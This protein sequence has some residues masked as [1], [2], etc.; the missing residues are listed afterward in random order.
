MFT[1]EQAR[2][3][4]GYY[5]SLKGDASEFDPEFLKSE[6]WNQFCD[7]AP[8]NTIQK[9]KEEIERRHEGAENFSQL[10]LKITQSFIAAPAADGEPGAK[11]QKEDVSDEEWRVLIVAIGG[12]RDREQLKSKIKGPVDSLLE[13]HAGYNIGDITYFSYMSSGRSVFEERL[14]I[15]GRYEEVFE[16]VKDKVGQTFDT[17]KIPKLSASIA[18]GFLGCFF[19]DTS[20]A[21]CNWSMERV[22]K[23]L[24]NNEPVFDKLLDIYLADKRRD[25]GGAVVDYG[26]CFHGGFYS[27]LNRELANDRSDN[28]TIVE[29]LKNYCTKFKGA[30]AAQKAQHKA[31]SQLDLPPLPAALDDDLPPL[32]AALDADLPSPAVNIFSRGSQLQ[33]SR[34]AGNTK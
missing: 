33:S 1:E 22:L 31:V 34:G 29:A 26:N 19:K 18:R 13:E 28:R 8:F 27:S 4:F 24:K 2:E 12:N 17:A 21:L 23:L 15:L 3:V 7:T 20:G 11:R 25:F 10:I 16:R 9:F 32:P 5:K 6:V 30:A 14:E